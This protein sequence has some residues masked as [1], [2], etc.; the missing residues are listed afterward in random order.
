MVPAAGSSAA[1]AVFSEFRYEM[2]TDVD[3]AIFGDGFES[4]DLSRW[5]RSVPALP[6]P[7]QPEPP[8]PR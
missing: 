3:P 1:P 2:W 8:G 6:P 7:S 4:G 5:T